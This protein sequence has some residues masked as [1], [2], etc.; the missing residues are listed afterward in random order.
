MKGSNS[1]GKLFEF[2]KV[3]AI[4]TLSYVLV[5]GFKSDMA[6]WK[7]NQ[8]VKA[9]NIQKSQMKKIIMSDTRLLFYFNWTLCSH[10]NLFQKMFI[11]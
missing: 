2:Y 7:Q 4:A 8:S 9:D 6:T 1:G 10:I 3:I 11:M 5:A